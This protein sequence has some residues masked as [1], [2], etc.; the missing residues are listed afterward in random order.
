MAGLWETWLDGAGETIHSFTV[1]TRASSPSMEFLHHRM[2]VLLPR[3]QERKWLE[4]SL[5]P[6]AFLEDLPSFGTDQLHVYRV[7]QQ[8][9]NVRNNDKALIEE[10]KDME[11]GSLF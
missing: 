1:L 5:D 4:E 7:S 6:I 8:V 11:Q 2:P 3:E 9:N 10:V